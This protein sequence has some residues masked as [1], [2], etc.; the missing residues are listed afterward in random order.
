M[1]TPDQISQNSM[2]RTARWALRDQSQ[3]CRHC[4]KPALAPTRKCARHQLLA[5]LTQIKVKYGLDSSSYQELVE[6]FGGKCYICK[7]T[8]LVYGLSHDR[9]KASR[10][11][12]VDH[13]HET[14]KI[15]GLLCSH[16]NQGLGH[17]KHNHELLMQAIQ[18]LKG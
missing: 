11:L 6:R 8:P 9:T 5:R 7:Q 12:S 10:T 17:F 14:G 13:C 1:K 15:R 2:V 3:R 4:D 18:Y 16:C